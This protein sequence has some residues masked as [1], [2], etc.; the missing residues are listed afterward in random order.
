MERPNKL[1][2]KNLHS[3]ISYM[4]NE[5]LC[6]IHNILTVFSLDVYLCMLHVHIQ[7]LL[8][9]KKTLLLDIKWNP[10]RYNTNSVTVSEK[11]LGKQ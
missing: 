3:A 1:A 11:N 4:L 2:W 7:I 6:H 9:N 10:F 5:L 8:P